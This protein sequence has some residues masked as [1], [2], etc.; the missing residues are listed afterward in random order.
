MFVGTDRETGRSRGFAFVEFASDQGAA[1]AIRKF[2]GFE[3][4]GRKIRV[5][6]ADERPRRP[7][8]P[9]S[10]PPHGG[11]PGGYAAAAPPSTG[12]SEPESD[13]FGGAARSFKNKG[14]RRNLRARKRSL[15]F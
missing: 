5:N 12:W 7:G 6:A 4:D 3:I 14:S 10:A 9:G 1:D 8:A 13:F 2:D 11:R 15:N